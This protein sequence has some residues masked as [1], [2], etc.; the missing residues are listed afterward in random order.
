MTSPNDPEANKALIERIYRDGYN[1]GDQSVYRECYTDDFVHHSKVTHDVSPGAEGEL[2]SMH[3]FRSAIP[4]VRFTI[5]GH[6]AEGD[7]V[8]TRLRISGTQVKDFGTVGV[9]DGRFDRHVLALFRITGGKVAEEWLFI[10][11]AD[12]P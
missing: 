9:G 2:E 11:A 4:D 1:G 6:V 12:G 3:N 7:L 8:A 5:L 10:D